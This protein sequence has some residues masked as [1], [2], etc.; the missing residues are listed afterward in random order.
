MKINN[1]NNT[2]FGE[3]L[4]GIDFNPSGDDKVK[5]AK[6]L[7]AEAANL[8]EDSRVASIASG[9]YTAMR[10]SI[11]DHAVGQVLNAQMCTVKL[12]TFEKH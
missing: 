8:L 5:K 10:Q 2:S 3:R 4:V 11:F 9:T 6:Q 12:L 1:N 7:F